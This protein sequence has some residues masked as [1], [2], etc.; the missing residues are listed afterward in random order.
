MNE[1][2]TTTLEGDDDVEHPRPSGKFSFIRAAAGFL[3]EDAPAGGVFTGPTPGPSPPR[4]ETVELVDLPPMALPKPP[5]TPLAH[6]LM[7]FA[8]IPFVI[9][10]ISGLIV[11]NRPSPRR[12]QPA[13]APAAV[14]DAEATSVTP[15]TPPAAPTT[16][17]RAVTTTQFPTVATTRAP[18]A[19]RAVTATPTTVTE[20]T[21]PPATTPSTEAPPTTEA[22]ATTTTTE[23]PTTTTTEPSTTT[24]TQPETTSSQPTLSEPPQ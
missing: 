24:T 8:L 14:P 11:I 19:P 22:P 1:S 20:T 12:Q 13:P 21:E 17:P 6:R 23:P 9:I 5:P 10:A 16:L 7:V 3:L 4:I 18:R 2:T 15:P